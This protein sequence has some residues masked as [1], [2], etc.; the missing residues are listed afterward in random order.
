MWRASRQWSGVEKRAT[1]QSQS[2]RQSPHSRHL[3]CPPPSLWILAPVTSHPHCLPVYSNMCQRLIQKQRAQT[4]W[5]L[6]QPRDWCGGRHL[7]LDPSPQS[8]EEK[9]WQGSGWTSP[10]WQ[11][12]HIQLWHQERPVDDRVHALH[13]PTDVTMGMAFWEQRQCPIHPWVLRTQLKADRRG[14]ETRKWRVQGRG[15]SNALEK[16]A[17]SLNLMFTFTSWE[18]WEDLALYYFWIWKINCNWKTEGIKRIIASRVVL[19]VLV[20]N[21]TEITSN[22][23]GW[24]CYFLNGRTLRKTCF[25]S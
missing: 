25:E 12:P 9:R 21:Q 1:W 18:P 2:G 23:S 3:C 11:S 22:V 10:F 15:L 8:L 17:T 14:S 16:I 4:M 24:E 5:N 13:R 7:L 6:L 19:G 20:H